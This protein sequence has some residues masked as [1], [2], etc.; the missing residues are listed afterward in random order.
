MDNPFAEIFSPTQTAGKDS[1][2]PSANP[3]SSIFGGAPSSSGVDSQVVQKSV[4]AV[5]PQPSGFGNFISHAWDSIKSFFTPITPA[6]TQT[7]TPKPATDFMSKVTGGFNAPLS[8]NPYLTQFKN[9]SI[10]NLSGVQFPQSDDAYVN[11]LKQGAIDNMPFTQ[12]AKDIINNGIKINIGQV[13]KG[14]GAQT[15]ISDQTK[16]PTAITI[17]KGTGSQNDKL[18]LNHEIFNSLFLRENINPE[19]FNQA[20]EKAINSN[21]PNAA[22]LRSID[23]QIHDPNNPAYNGKTGENVNTGDPYYLATERFA[24]AGKTLGLDGISAVPKDL[25]SFYSK[26]LNDYQDKTSQAT[27]SKNFIDTLHQGVQDQSQKVSA[28]ID[29]ISTPNP[30]PLRQQDFVD[31]LNTIPQALNLLTFG[32]ANAAVGGILSLSE[33]VAGKPLGH[34]TIPAIGSG[35]GPEKMKQLVESNQNLENQ[36][37]KSLADLS[38]Q[39]AQLEQYKKD[40]N[41]S[42][43]NSLVPKYNQALNDHNSLVD[44]YKKGV[45]LYN[46]NLGK[47]EKRGVIFDAEGAKQYFQEQLDN[48]VPEKQAFWNTAI[49]TVVDFSMLVPLARS[50]SKFALLKTNPEALISEVKL[51]KQNVYDYLTGR[52][53][54]EELNMPKEVTN[55]IAD[56]MKNGTREQKIQLVQGLGGAGVKASRLGQF[57]GVS[58]T[59]AEALWKAAQPKAGPTQLL[60]GETTT[61]GVPTAEDISKIAEDIKSGQPS[62]ETPTMTIPKEDIQ[63]IAKQYQN[64]PETISSTQENG[65]PTIVP[66]PDFRTFDFH[67]L[68]GQPQTKEENAKI[69]NNIVNNPDQ[70][71]TPGGESFNQAAERALTT[72]NQIMVKEKGN[73]AVTTHNSMYGLLKLWS[74]SGQPTALDQTFR[75]KYVKQD[76]SNPTGSHFVIK[77]PNGDIYVVRHG[78]TTDNAEGVFRRSS[79]KLTDK[80]RDEAKDLAND[81]QGKGITKIYSSDLPRAIETSQI[82]QKGIGKN[83][84]IDN[85]LEINNNEEYGKPIINRSQKS[86]G[87]KTSQGN[88]STTPR[89]GGSNVVSVL[90]SFGQ[91]NSIAGKRA[92]QDFIR[93]RGE[94]DKAWADRYESNLKL[95]VSE[96]KLDGLSTGFNQ[97]HSQL[98]NAV[99][100]D[101]SS[102]KD[103]SLY[104]KSV[105]DAL[106]TLGFPVSFSKSLIKNFDSLPDSTKNKLDK[107]SYAIYSTDYIG[108][109]YPKNNGRYDFWIGNKPFSGT[110]QDPIGLTDHEMGWHTRWLNTNSTTKLD[111]NDEI[112][113]SI[114]GSKGDEF[115]IKLFK[116]SNS[117]NYYIKSSFVKELTFLKSVIQDSFTSPNLAESFNQNVVDE[118]NKAT[119]QLESLQERTLAGLNNRKIIS[120]I[121]IKVA[122]EYISLNTNE[123]KKSLNNIKSFDNSLSDEIGARMY[124]Q[125][126]S[127]EVKQALD[128]MPNIKS[129]DIFGGEKEFGGEKKPD[130]QRGYFNREKIN[131]VSLLR[132]ELEKAQGH[133]DMA[134]ANKELFGDKIPDLKSKVDDLRA[135]IKEAKF[136]VAETPKEVLEN[137]EKRTGVK[138]VNIPQIQNQLAREQMSLAA[139]KEAP[140]AHLKAYGEDRV[141]KYEARIKELETKLNNAVEAPALPKAPTIRVSSKDIN[142]PEE[143]FHRQL[144]LDI[145]K[146]E[147]NQN[148]AQHLS[149]YVAQSGEFKGELPEVTAKIPE[150]LSKQN[151]ENVIKWIKH[152]DDI[153]TQFGFKDSEEARQAWN[154]YVE[155]KDNLRLERKQLRTEIDSFIKS[156]KDR[157]GIEKFNQMGDQAVEKERTKEQKRIDREQEKE[158]LANWK[159][160]IATYAKEASVPQSLEEVEPPVGRGGVKSPVLDLAKANDKGWM[161]RDSI[162]RNIEKTFTRDDA[163]KLNEFLSDT[164]RKNATREVEFVDRYLQPLESEMEKLGIK[165]NSDEAKF[166]QIYGEGLINIDQLMKEFPD[167]WKKIEE[168]VPIYKK[169]YETS[170]RELNSERI[171]FGLDPIKPLK[172]YFPHFDAISFWTK[173]YGILNKNDDLPTSIAGKTQNFKPNKAFTRHE[174]HRTGRDTAYDA[175]EGAKEYIKSIAR[176]FASIDNV[177]HGKAV[178][179]YITKS[180]EVAE[181]LGTPLHLQAF[182][183]NLQEVIQNQLANKMGGL[184]R[185]GEKFGDRKIINSVETISKLVGKNIIAFNPKIFLTHLVSVAI[186]AA[187]VNKIDFIKGM[188]TTVSSPFFQENGK[189]IPYYMIDGQRSDLLYR[190]YPKQYL[191]T[192]FENIEKIGGVFVTTADIFKTRTAIA[193]KYYELT[194]QGMDPKEAIKK[195]DIY[196]GHIVGDYSRGMKPILLNQ[197]FFKILAQFQFGMNDGMSVLLHDIPYNSRKM[198]TTPN[199][200]VIEMFKGKDGVWRE[201]KDYVKMWWKIVQWMVFAYLM[202]EAL[203]KKVTGSGKGLNPIGLALTLAGANDEGRGQTFGNRI[204]KVFN[205]VTGDLAGELPFTNVLGGNLPIATAITQPIKDL[206]AGNYAKAG[207]GAA[208]NF[209][210]PFG[211]GLQ[212]KKSTEGAIAYNKGYVANNAGVPQY[213]IPKGVG[214]A[215]QSVLF[216]P[217]GNQQAQTFYNTKGSTSP[218]RATYDEVQQLVAEG[219]QSEAQAIVDGLSDAEYKSYTAVKSSVKAQTTKTAE[220]AF[221]PRTQQIQN[222][223]K[224][225]KSDEAQKIVNAM[226][227]EEYKYYQG[228]KKLLTTANNKTQKTFGGGSSTWDKQSFLTHVFTIA[229]AATLHPI[230]YFN[231]VFDGA[232]DWRATGVENG[233][234][235]VARNDQKE[236]QTKKDLGGNPQ[237]ILD[238]V[239][240][241]ELGGNNTTNNMW[242]IPKAQSLVDDQVENYLGNALKSGKITGPQAQEYELRYKKGA[243]AQWIDD[244]TKKLFDKVGDSLTLD[245]IKSEVENY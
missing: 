211:G 67:E 91:A 83:K 89:S 190:R 195:A 56:T 13:D 16:G 81:L 170:L 79:T 46:Q 194:R 6:D 121:M 88:E 42:A 66:T 17:Q 136:P 215:I 101:L 52:K 27:S 109:I 11:S 105:A 92:A 192:T 104:V 14:S 102:I 99:L 167:N 232:G 184:D 145:N 216:G 159:S 114:T 161:A 187:T 217:S 214:S 39:E 188:M 51:E 132:K 107:I 209:V 18:A 8:Q 153:A 63:N 68:E 61:P 53:T 199:G 28:L 77:G 86:I 237:V 34:A 219:K 71:M 135:Q 131:D 228:S 230:Q 186:N 73:I 10:P 223:I 48:K 22:V 175:I 38:R 119:R 220:V 35:L 207:I 168:A 193:S 183:T 7:Q 198:V 139:A 218:M 143:L 158:S 100:E 162:D 29:K 181:R 2:G 239:K 238:H 70:P 32:L 197:K 130:T 45:D 43:Y 112:K 178:D 54:A 213:P 3:F 24:N 205:P 200:K 50:A 85:S 245:Q 206:F 25:Q 126:N 37:T 36:M 148:P 15:L 185:E 127:N 23:A 236:S 78:E 150:K 144:S 173:N 134:I 240:S 149:K 202:D 191:P 146:E 123:I 234:I 204:N 154:K 72:I 117:A 59:E 106:S 156:E 5:N 142:I 57:L 62:T 58:Q 203:F 182:Q 244:R 116:N 128:K 94:Q 4:N 26:F 151:R 90:E 122:D 80:G 1:S 179:K 120:D 208:A 47:E 189:H 98:T 75:E 97:K 93:Q 176:Q 20:W 65:K 160:I 30:T 64:T 229:K 76:N 141:P 60:T 95:Y 157:I 224:D 133:L 84:I 118:I 155:K 12:S 226:T 82:I 87:G 137:I 177:A 166:V 210:S 163:I 19:Q 243:D 241:L 9:I 111:I 221:L 231:N 196:G 33:V 225:G 233:Q 129:L 172:N 242:L 49:K 55:A 96:T 40:G 115:L 171:K 108:G 124:E 212:V 103:K 222:L 180:A 74:E 113:S 110:G 41:V 125:N 174:L 69:H 169:I 165:P 235:I 21:D 44:T 140:E 152:G 164:F 31:V 201:K 227:D 147:L 138:P